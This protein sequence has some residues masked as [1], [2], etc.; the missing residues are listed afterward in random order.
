[1]HSI[2][3]QLFHHVHLTTLTIDVVKPVNEKI[4]SFADAQR[5]RF[6]QLV[7]IQ[8]ALVQHASLEPTLWWFRNRFS[9]SRYVT[10]VEQQ[11]DLFRMLHN[12]DAI[13]SDPR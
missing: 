2:Y 7:S 3:D 13:V 9:S 12:I 4:K 6:H 5:S 11:I 1:M 10:L 8:R